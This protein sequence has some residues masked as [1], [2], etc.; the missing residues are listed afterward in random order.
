MCLRH[1]LEVYQC[2]HKGDSK[3]IDVLSISRVCYFHPIALW[4]DWIKDESS[5]AVS[6]DD[7]KRILELYEKATVDYLCMSSLRWIY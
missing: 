7:K 5:I 4:L 2:F 3:Q 6:E 1:R